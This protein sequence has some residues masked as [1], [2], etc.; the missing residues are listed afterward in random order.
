MTNQ[1][2]FHRFKKQLSEHYVF[3]TRYLFKFIVPVS[4][5]R[6]FRMLF[7]T[8]EFETRSSKTKKFISFSKKILV[9]SSDE[10]IEIYEKAY[11]IE[12]IISL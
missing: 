3:P 12:G 1:S 4:K 9:H 6:E 7:D 2:D 5:E 10:I 8:V 11:S